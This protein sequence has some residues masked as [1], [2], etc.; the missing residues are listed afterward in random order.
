M[1]PLSTAVAALLFNVYAAFG[2][3]LIVII[4]DSSAVIIL[5]R[6]HYARPSEE[7]SGTLLCIALSEKNGKNQKY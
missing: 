6:F 5:H 4:V 2:L 7:N 1:L 3:V